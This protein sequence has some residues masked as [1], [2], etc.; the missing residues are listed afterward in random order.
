MPIPDVNIIYETS[1]YRRSQMPFAGWNSGDTYLAQ[2]DT[3]TNPNGYFFIYG[4][5]GSSLR[6]GAYEKDALSKKDY[7]LVRPGYDCQIDIPSYTYTYSWYYS[8]FT[9]PRFHPDWRN[10]VKFTIWKIGQPERLIRQLR[11]WNVPPGDDKPIL[12]DFFGLQDADPREYRPIG[13][14]RLQ[15][16]KSNS[17]P[18]SFKHDLRLTLISR[19]SPKAG[20]I[21]W[22]LKIEA[23]DGG[24]QETSDKILYTA[25][26]AEYQPDLEYES[27]HPG[28]I[29]SHRYYAQLVPMDFYRTLYLKTRGGTIYGNM[30]VA[31]RADNRPAF[32][33]TE[34]HLLYTINPA[35]SRNLETAPKHTIDLNEWLERRGHGW[36]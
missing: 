17:D 2:Y 19:K 29:P 28:A 33:L 1:H 31:I 20:K 5:M 32:G 18:Q 27:D 11:K 25:P 22:S 13:G 4:G 12:V 10:P 30:L 21:Q 15:T 14:K 34:I 35:G 9:N 23:I 24:L 26:Q 8:D 3:K 36:D 16:A 7:R 6:V